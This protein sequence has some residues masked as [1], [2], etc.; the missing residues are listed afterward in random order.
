VCRSRKAQQKEQHE[1]PASEE[2]VVLRRADVGPVR[3]NL[4]AA[5]VISRRSILA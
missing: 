4:Y 2:L 3:W 1:V 5:V